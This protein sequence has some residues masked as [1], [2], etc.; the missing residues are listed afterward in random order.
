MKTVHENYIR[1]ADYALKSARANI[2]RSR[3]SKGYKK[4]LA[5]MRW[6][7][8]ALW[9]FTS[10]PEV[11]LEPDVHP[12]NCWPFS[13]DQSQILVKLTEKFQPAAV[14]LHHIAMAIPRLAEISSAPKDFAIYG[15]N[16]EAEE[17]GTFLGQFTYNSEGEPVQIFPLEVKKTDTFQYIRLKVL[18]N[19]GNPDYTC[20]YRFRVHRELPHEAMQRQRVENN[21]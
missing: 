4:N 7:N 19:W 1:I 14:T 18:S 16:E 21:V 11:I 5:R 3:T 17:N 13:S 6:H 9:S 2:V 8:F 10:N 15:L 20:I 12:G